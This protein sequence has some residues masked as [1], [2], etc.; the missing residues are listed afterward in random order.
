MS[1]AGLLRGSAIAGA[2][3]Q[4]CSLEECAAADVQ[5]YPGRTALVVSLE[6][7]TENVYL[8]NQRSMTIPNCLFRLGGAAVLLSNRR[9]HWW[10]ARSVAPQLWKV[11]QSCT[12][13]NSGKP[14]KIT[15]DT[16]GSGRSHT[17]ACT[18][19]RPS[20]LLN[21]CNVHELIHRVAH[22]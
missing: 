22:G 8:G 17:G 6:N 20:I 3:A 21:K 7:I 13:K 15:E 9:R 10:T 4:S 12:E 16:T 19:C 2:N 18:R 11:P 5:V 14:R 1:R